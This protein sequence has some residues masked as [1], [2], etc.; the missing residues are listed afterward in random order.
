M[1]VVFLLNMKIDNIL[2]HLREV[3]T[4][5]LSLSDKEKEIGVI[6]MSLEITLK[7]FIFS[8]IS[9]FKYSDAHR[10][11]FTKIRRTKILVEM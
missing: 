10:N 4:K 5:L 1:V 6:A 8:K 11:S 7:D 2:D 3:P 9:I